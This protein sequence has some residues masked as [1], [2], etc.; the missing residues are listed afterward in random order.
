[1]LTIGLRVLAILIVVYAAAIL[2]AWRFQDRL[3]F[4]GPSGPL[5]PP[6]T[7]GLPEGEIVTVYTSDGVALKGWYLPPVPRPDTGKAP[8][9]IWFHGNMETIGGIGSILRDFRPPGMGVLA[10]DYRG[11]GESE[12]RPSERGVYR[13]ALAAWDFLATH[14]DI[15]STRIGVYGRSIGAAV[16]LY[17]ATERGV[18]AVVLESPFTS[19]KDMA[20]KHYALVPTSLM[21]LRLNNLRRAEQLSIPLIVF[22]GMDDWIAP[23]EMGRSVADAGRAEELVLLPDAGHNDTYDVGGDL[24]RDKM[25]DFLRRHL[26][27]SRP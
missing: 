25:H 15:D 10:L 5:P 6:A 19:G 3:A 13:D 12:G 16:A 18:R 4:P 7:V 17:L 8:G 11:Y 26:T 24:Y 23:V 20:K 27:N 2:L 14:P 1:M 9:L 21:T 22:H